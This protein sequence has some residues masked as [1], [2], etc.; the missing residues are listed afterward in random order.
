MPEL[1]KRP[2]S[3]YTRVQASQP[4]EMRQSDFTH[5]RLVTYVATQMR[6]MSRLITP[7]KPAGGLE[8][9]TP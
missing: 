2:R 9:P 1:R 7:T 3:S 8:P 6:P 5:S 4:N